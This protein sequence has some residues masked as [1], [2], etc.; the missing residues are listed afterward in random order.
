MQ[1]HHWHACGYVLFQ[2]DWP[3]TQ[4]RTEQD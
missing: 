1:E 4:A 3:V 2:D